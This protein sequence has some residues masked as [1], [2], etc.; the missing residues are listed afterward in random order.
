LA[1]ALVVWFVVAAGLWAA[2]E[3]LRRGRQEV[4]RNARP[5]AVGDGSD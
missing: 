4:E 3:R 1:C 5:A 2:F